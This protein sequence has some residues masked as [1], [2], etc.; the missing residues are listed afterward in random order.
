MKKPPLRPLLS[1]REPAVSVGTHIK[2]TNRLLRYL[3]VVMG[4]YLIDFGIYSVFASSGQSIYLGH[5]VGFIV[6]GTINVIL[7]RRFV[8][9]ESR[10]H[11]AKDVF[12]S[13][14]TNGG[15]LVL[16]VALLWV[17]TQRL[18]VNPYYAKLATNGITFA[19]NYVTRSI[20]FSSPRNP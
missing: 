16:G 3:A 2:V 20:F 11:L 8:F 6:G 19:I 18:S 1:P 5:T 14:G 15:M 12:L 13:L 7:I 10:F 4:G 9:T 17:L